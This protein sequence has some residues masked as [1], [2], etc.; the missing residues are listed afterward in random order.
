MKITLAVSMILGIQ[1]VAATSLKILTP[2]AL[3]DLVDK[4]GGK[5]EI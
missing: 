5:G 1:Q 2:N 3:I 4:R